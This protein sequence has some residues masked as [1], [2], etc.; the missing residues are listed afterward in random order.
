MG[1]ET[2]CPRCGEPLS[3]PNLMHAEF[4]CSRHGAVPPLQPAALPDPAVLVSLAARSDVALWLPW[5]LPPTWL[6]TGVRLVG[7]GSNGRVLATAMGL[8]GQGLENGPS[9]L[10]IVAE[11][12]GTGLG[13]RLAGIQ[14]VDP[15]SVFVGQESVAKIHAGG[16][17]TPLWTVPSPDRSI[18]VGE[19][20][21]D[22]LWLISWPASGWGVVHGDLR[23]VDLRE[24]AQ[25]TD[26]PTGALMPRLKA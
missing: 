13:S 26:L 23:L 15:G 7:G 12:P 11:K 18:Y 21:G 5:P 3:S 17:P 6:F 9:D 22:W 4:L 10:L 1:A 24:T 19:A 14:Q 25:L 16:W 20:G 8:T 2:Q